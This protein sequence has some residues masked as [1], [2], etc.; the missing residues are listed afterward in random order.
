MT[1]QKSVYRSEIDQLNRQIE[2]IK[3]I[4]KLNSK[5]LDLNWIF[6]HP[7]NQGFEVEYFEKIIR[8]FSGKKAEEKIFE[9]HAR[10]FLNLELTIT[11]VDGFY[12]KRPYLSDFADQVE[13]SILLCIQKDFGGA[14]TLIIPTIE[15]TIRNYLISKKGN[16]AK[17]AIK[18]G[19][20][21]VAFKYMADD[22][23][24]L[25][26]HYLEQRFGHLKQ[27][28][29]YFDHNQKKQILKKHRTY[30][31]LWMDQLIKYL[32]N[33]FYAD[34]RKSKQLDDKFNRHNLVHGMEHV[35]YNFRNYLRL[36]NCLNYLNW[37]IGEIHKDCSPLAEIEESL[38]KS[39]WLEYFKVLIIS[40]SI[41]DSKRKILG[42][43]IE[44]FNRFIDKRLTK[45]LSLSTSIHKQ[46]LKV[47]DRLNR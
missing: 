26:S 22:Y 7:Y 25:Q 21:K 19:D 43:E 33:S 46:L 15:G 27:T 2:L 23:V 34:T 30:F 24:K 42:K 39:K 29:G 37:A 5:L 41:T 11:F 17:S 6:F 12:R 4:A 38:V 16:S 13:E 32:N 31:D 28:D 20:L 8:D 35:D 14:I 3:R 18:L 40:E 10:K 1:L 45:P 36:L 44:S 9:Q 47:N